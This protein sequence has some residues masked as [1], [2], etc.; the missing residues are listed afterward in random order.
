VGRAVV[1]KLRQHAVRFVES[2]QHTTM[3]KTA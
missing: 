2:D 1:R 3:R